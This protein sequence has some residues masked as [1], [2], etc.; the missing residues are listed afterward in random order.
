MVQK[1]YRR[2][3]KFYVDVENSSYLSP[4]LKEILKAAPLME[5]AIRT[6]LGNGMN[7]CSGWIG[8]VEI[9]RLRLLSHGSF[10]WTATSAIQYS[11]I[12]KLWQ[13]KYNG[14]LICEGISRKRRKQSLMPWLIICTLSVSIFLKWIARVHLSKVFMKKWWYHSKFTHFFT[15]LE[16]SVKGASF[17]AA[18]IC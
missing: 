9:N 12:I 10:S 16:V 17:H 11:S 4:V 5:Q 18:P 3:K 2:H 14:M 6:K 8:G 1:H 15:S 7:T 13:G